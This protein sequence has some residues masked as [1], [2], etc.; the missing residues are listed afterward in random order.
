MLAFKDPLDYKKAEE[1]LKQRI[2]LLKS[3]YHRLSKKPSE[4]WQINLK[5]RAAFWGLL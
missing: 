1:I 2:I 5:S 3:L 4:N